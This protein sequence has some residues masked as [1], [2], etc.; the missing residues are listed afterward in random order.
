M[1][2]SQ[3]GDALIDLGPG[4]GPGLGLDWVGEIGRCRQACRINGA[5]MYPVLVRACLTLVVVGEGKEPAAA[6]AEPSPIQFVPFRS[7]LFLTSHICSRPVSTTMFNVQFRPDQSNK[8]TSLGREEYRPN[9]P[10]ARRL[11][12]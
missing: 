7:V 8:G 2:V 4:L 3:A 9:R 12:L 10:I 6:V 5:C 1:L 11:K